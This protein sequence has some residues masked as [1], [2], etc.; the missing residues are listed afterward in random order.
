MA[1]TKLLNSTDPNMD[2]TLYGKIHDYLGCVLL[3]VSQAALS[4]GINTCIHY[5]KVNIYKG[6]LICLFPQ[7]MPKHEFYINYILGYRWE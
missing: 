1:L 6:K 2:P 3:I 4:C 7:K 5:Q